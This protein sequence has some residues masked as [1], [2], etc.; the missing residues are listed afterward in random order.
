MAFRLVSNAFTNDD[1]IPVKFT[2]DGD[3]VS[4]RLSWSD[5]PAKTVSFALVMEDLDAKPKRIHWLLW[6]IPA[7]T[8][9]LPEAVPRDP[10]LPDGTCQG[11]NDFNKVGYSGPR[12][13]QVTEHSY[14]FKLYALD[15]KL[16]LKAGSSHAEL[17]AVMGG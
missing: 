2:A 15:S 1:L 4:P 9:A 3:D 12:L 6:N 13:A 8:R 16:D 14:E 17:T 7:R 5:P 11:R 10:V